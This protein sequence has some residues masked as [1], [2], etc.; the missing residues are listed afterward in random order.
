MVASLSG[1]FAV[2]KTREATVQKG[3]VLPAAGTILIN[4]TVHLQVNQ[5]IQNS[6]L[7]G[8]RYTVVL[9]TFL[10]FF[11]YG[12]MCTL[13]GDGPLYDSFNPP[14]LISK[15]SILREGSIPQTLKV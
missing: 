5:I 12:Q 14:K 13:L 9:D 10:L 2:M 1:S 15:R 7:Q 6:H 11:F 3:V 8:K 4:G